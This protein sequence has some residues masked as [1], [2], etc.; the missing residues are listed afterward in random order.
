MRTRIDQHGAVVDHRIAVVLHAVFGGHVVI[1]ITSREM[2][3]KRGVA[4]YREREEGLRLFLDSRFK[5]RYE[6]VELL[7]P[8]GPAVTDG[9]LE[10]LVVSA[11]TR[12]RGEEINALRRKSGHQPLELIVVPR[13]LAEDGRPI[14]A[15]RIRRGEIDPEGRALE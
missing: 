1:G 13:V 2:R 6:V 12:R 4:P 14:S 8:Y 15:T 3:E 9:S 10:A 7:D 11:E 5:G